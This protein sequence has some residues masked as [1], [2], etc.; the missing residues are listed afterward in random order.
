MLNLKQETM[1]KRIEIISATNPQTLKS[2]LEDMVNDGWEIKGVIGYNPHNAYT[3]PF[4][5]L[6]SSVMDE[7]ARYQSKY[8]EDTITEQFNLKPEPPKKD[9]SISVGS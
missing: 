9:I 7:Y 2:Q 1:A 3:E 4:V 5:I 6:E 8:P